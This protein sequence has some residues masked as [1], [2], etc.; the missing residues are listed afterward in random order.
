MEWYVVWLRGLAVLLICNT[1]LWLWSIKLRNVSIV[2]I[3]WGLGF[4]V[5]GGVYAYELQPIATRNLVVLGALTIWGLRLAIHL[6]LRNAGKG[7]DYRY[8]QFRK[9][10]GPERYWWFSFFQVFVLQG[11]LAWLIS[12]PLLAVAISKNEWSLWDSLALAVWS[13]GFFFEAVGDAQLVRFKR[14]SENKGKLLTTGLWR[15]TRH[16]NYFGDAVVWWA[17]ALWATAAGWWPALLAAG[18]MTFLL[19]RVSGVALLE[20]TLVQRKPGYEAYIRNTNAFF[21]GL[22]RKN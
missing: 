22:P 4:V 21:P 13:I 16:P 11:V 2:D 18:L 6:F 20:R 17:F 7:E 15:F 8:Q 9:Q 5:V 14:K 1:L 19:M 10:Y 12:F 3:W